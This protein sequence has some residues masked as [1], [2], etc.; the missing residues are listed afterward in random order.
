MHPTATRIH[1]CKPQQTL[2]PL[3]GRISC[4]NFMPHIVQNRSKSTTRQIPA[5][6]VHYHNSANTSLHCSSRYIAISTLDR[7][8]HLSW[9]TVNP[10]ERLMG[11]SAKEPPAQRFRSDT[12][13]YVKAVSGLKSFQFVGLVL[14]EPSNKELM[15]FCCL[16]YKINRL[17]KTK[18]AL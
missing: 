2:K 10:W 7:I 11:G 5:K 18:R 1:R 6:A 13:G 17:D 4:L 8:D 16:L 9:I 14:E 15:C 3:E 12:A